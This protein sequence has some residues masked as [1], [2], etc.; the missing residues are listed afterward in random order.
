MALDWSKCSITPPDLITT[1]TGDRLQDSEAFGTQAFYQVN[2]YLKFVSHSPGS[3]VTTYSYNQAN[4]FFQSV[5]IQDRS[6]KADKTTLENE[7]A[8]CKG[9]S[10]EWES[11]AHHGKGEVASCQKKYNSLF[12]K[13][14]LETETVLQAYLES[15]RFHEFMDDHDDKMH[16]VNMTL[17]WNKAIRVVNARYPEVVNPED[18]PIPDCVVSADQ[19]ASCSR[20]KAPS[21]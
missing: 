20:G 9:E 14:K 12:K 11:R 18:F 8:R 21:R 15:D 19:G 4:A 6:L 2:L 10:S 5:C 3:F 13:K 1:T 17:G 16:P 7:L